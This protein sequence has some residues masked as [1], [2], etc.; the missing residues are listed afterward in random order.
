[1]Q[2]FID[3]RA[4]VLNDVLDDAFRH[5]YPGFGLPTMMTFNEW[6]RNLPQDFEISLLA[7]PLKRLVT[8]DLSA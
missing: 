7:R 4:A 6:P 3:L 5:R 2:P 8:E 1:M